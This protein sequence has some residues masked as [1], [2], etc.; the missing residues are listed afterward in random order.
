MRKEF[1][2]RVGKVVLA[3]AVLLSGMSSAA[4][5]DALIWYRV[6]GDPDPALPQ[7]LDLTAVS[8][9]QSFDVELRVE[10]TGAG[11]NIFSWGHDLTASDT[12]V[13]ASNLAT[14]P[15]FPGMQGTVPGASPLLT[16]DNGWFSF[17]GPWP[18]LGTHTVMSLTL[19]RVGPLDNST[20]DIDATVNGFEWVEL[21]AGVHL[22][23]QPAGRPG[24]TGSVG[25]ALGTM[26]QITAIPEP[27]TLGLLA[28]GA[29]AMLRRRMR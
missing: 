16:V 20:V 7:I 17:N 13:S 28:F 25:N 29:L 15:S 4:L 11:E 2:M 9:N 19:T 23:V 14:G 27:A 18:G 6:V 10:I 3:A 1:G 24:V 21:N 26:I 5:G 22:Q 12:T 8:V